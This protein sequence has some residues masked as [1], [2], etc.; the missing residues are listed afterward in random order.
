MLIAAAQKSPQL[1]AQL[2]E[3]MLLSELLGQRYGVDRQNFVAQVEQRIR[4][5]RRGEI[6]IEEQVEDLRTLAQNELGEWQLR[7]RR[8]RTAR[9][10]LTAAALVLV[11]GGISGWFA[12]TPPAWQ[13]VVVDAVKGN[14]SFTPNST[15]L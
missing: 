12:F 10:W 2:K 14:A 13:E 11:L 9:Y 3:Q 15:L 4:D 1:A 7:Q 8:S 6:E 5:Y